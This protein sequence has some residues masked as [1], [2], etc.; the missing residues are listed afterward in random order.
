M[1]RRRNRTEWR[2]GIQSVKFGPERRKWLA[3]VM[4]GFGAGGIVLTIIRPALDAAVEFQ[5]SAMYG[6]PISLALLFGAY[7]ILGPLDEDE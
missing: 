3:T 4:T 6:V 2:A 5:W 7:Y 1:T